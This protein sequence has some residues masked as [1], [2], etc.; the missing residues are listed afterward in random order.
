MQSKSSYTKVE[1][2][3]ENLKYWKD[4][5]PGTNVDSIQFSSEGVEKSKDCSQFE[6]TI[7][8]EDKNK[9]R[10]LEEFLSRLTGKRVKF[11]ITDSIKLDDDT[12]ECVDKIKNMQMGRTSSNSGRKGWGLEYNFSNTTLESQK[13]N[14]NTKGIIK[15]LDGRT[16]DI[17][18]ELNM[19]RE[20]ISHTS[21]N[22]KAGDALID[23]LIINY[24][25]NTPS[26]TKKIYSFD[27]NM[28]GG[29]E[30][31]SFP[32]EGSGFL[33]LDSNNDGVINDGKELFGP[34]SGSGFDELKKYD[35]DGNN[36]IDE[37]DSIFNRLQI[38]TKDESGNDK[39]F[40]LGQA[41]IGAVFLGNISTQFDINNNSNDTL[42][43]VQSSGI[44]LK[45]DGT[46]GVIQ[47]LDISV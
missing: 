32:T 2:T 18:V 35:S 11:K 28:D 38:W 36:W 3:E 39:L 9:I 43:K 12:S 1:T 42:G 4:S 37:N 31:I 10:L 30:Q 47:H 21:L 14:F 20:F 33:A 26:L 6:L 8:E 15:T 24:S 22:I 27:I 34:S 5:N 40:A 25:G 19:S 29:L 13:M 7:S 44:F 16:I 45:E 23:P 17:S 41:G 46:P